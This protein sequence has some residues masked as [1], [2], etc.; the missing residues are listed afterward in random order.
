MNWSNNDDPLETG[1]FVGNGP[2]KAGLKM[3]PPRK[4]GKPFE[5]TFL[6]GL[7]MRIE[8]F[9]PLIV[10]TTGLIIALNGLIAAITTVLDLVK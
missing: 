7:S 8:K 4:R 9:V 2:S 6:G 3:A 10:A 1:D 5:L